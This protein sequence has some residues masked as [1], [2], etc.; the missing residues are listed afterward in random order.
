V[1]AEDVSIREAFGVAGAC[2][3]DGDIFFAPVGEPFVDGQWGP[4]MYQSGIDIAI[5]DDSDWGA[6][7]S[8]VDHFTWGD[9]LEDKSVHGFAMAV[10]E[11]GAGPRNWCPGD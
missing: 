2:T 9:E 3:E 4:L 11:D 6:H 10:W 5:Y 8:D 7:P 1:L